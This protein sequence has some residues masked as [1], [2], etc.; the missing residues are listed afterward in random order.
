MSSAVKLLRPVPEPERFARADWALIEASLD[1]Q[2][3]AVVPGVLSPEECDALRALYAQPKLFR[4]R[5]VMARHAYGMG[6]YQY[7]A[8]PLP[9][10][11]QQMRGA[12]YPHLAAIANRW[13]EMLNVDARYPAT[14]EAFLQVCHDN[15]Q[16]RPTPLMLKYTS[17][18]YNRLHQDLY[19]K[20][21]FPLQAVTLLNAPGRDFEGGE[22]VLTESSARMQTKAEVVPLMQ[23]DM[24]I[25]A[26]NARPVKSARGFRR[27]AM[28]HGVSRIRA[29]DRMTL[30]LIF[31]DA[32]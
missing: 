24:A 19:G 18:D 7:F 22:L 27:A 23:G 21:Q 5:V 8:Y 32:T 11:V 14:H 29:G 10:L 4:S 12:L 9:P 15:G 17:G 30:G 26:V 20:T 2:G 13:M 16:I 25:F 28:R 6:E 3:F 1:A 31:H